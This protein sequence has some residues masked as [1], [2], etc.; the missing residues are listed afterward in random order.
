MK[1]TT[2]ALAYALMLRANADAYH[3]RLVEHEA[4]SASNRAIW[5]RIELRPRTKKNVL[6]ILRGAR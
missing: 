4:F 1:D 2:T 3:N 5:D 6:A